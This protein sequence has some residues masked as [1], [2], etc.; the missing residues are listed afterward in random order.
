MTDQPLYR[1]LPAEELAREYSPSTC[2]GG[3]IAPYVRRYISESAQARSTCRLVE[4]AAYGPGET[5]VLDLFLPEGVVP[6]PVHVFIHGGYWQELSHKE[7][8]VM[9]QG[10]TGRGI[11]LAV[12]NYTLAPDATI[13]EMVGECRMALQWLRAHAS[14]HGLDG[15]RI[16]ASGH[17]AGAH[18]LAMVLVSEPQACSIDAALL[19][20]GIYD[21]EPI[22][23][24][25]VNDPLG[26]DPETARTL[27]PLFHDR[28]PSCPLRVVVAENETAEF[29]RQSQAYADRLRTAGAKA[30]DEI[31]DGLNHF[32][33][34]L[35]ERILEDIERM[36]RG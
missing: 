29:K 12:V 32:D 7:S 14:D 6:A 19:I 26:L 33:I 9:A 16:T 25:Y 28:V 10:L 17:S 1:G 20:S 34:I 31:Y 8:A 4:D 22:R 13:A 3:D 5:Q 35:S 15:A 27:S 36:T 30:S 18:L 24:T 11:A 2:V 23:L 21:L